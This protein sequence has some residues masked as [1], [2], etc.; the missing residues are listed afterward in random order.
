M[1]L[2]MENKKLKEFAASGN[3]EGVKISIMNKAN[4][5]DKAFVKALFGPHWDILEY[6]LYEG[7]PLDWNERYIDC[8]LA[9]KETGDARWH[10]FASYI[11]EKH[12]DSLFI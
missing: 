4:N 8:S 7:F 12:K 3:L 6:L 5:F 10:K 11:I 1:E 9:F 2:N